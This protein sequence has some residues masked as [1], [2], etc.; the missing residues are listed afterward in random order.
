MRGEERRGEEDGSVE[1]K[2]REAHSGRS[3][4]YVNI[5]IGEREP[6]DEERERWR[7]RERETERER[8]NA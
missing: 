5:S 8:E 1:R 2:K 6:G 3:F 7:E 4:G